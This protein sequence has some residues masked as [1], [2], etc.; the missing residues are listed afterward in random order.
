MFFRS[1][2][3]L[4]YYIIIGSLFLTIFSLLALVISIYDIVHGGNIERGYIYLYIGYTVEITLFALGLGQLQFINEKFRKEAQQ[5]LIVQLKENEKLQSRIE[6]QLRKEVYTLEKQMEQEELE[7]IQMRYEKELSE[8]KVRILSSQMNPH[9]IFNSLNSIKRYIIDNEQEHAVYYLNKFSKLIRKILASSMEKSISLAEEL[10]V[11]EL[12]ANIENIRF[13][14]EIAIHFEIDHSIS[15]DTIQVP[16]LLL[17]PFI[18]NAIWH[19]LSGLETKKELCIEIKKGE[20]DY[21]N[22]VITDNGRGRKLARE[23]RKKKIYKKDS[24]G[25]QITKERLTMFAKDKNTPFSFEIIDMKH[26]DGS[27]AGTKV[28]L[29]IPLVQN[30]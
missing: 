16:G 9:F 20:G 23:I 28:H 27:A 21:I 6:E 4:R 2:H 30:K 24:V 12:Y 7:N 1:R 14:N 26:K 29:K 13:N 17:Q 15:I 22:I 18:E 19:G 10:E 8:L 5:Q 11:V 3:P 25:L